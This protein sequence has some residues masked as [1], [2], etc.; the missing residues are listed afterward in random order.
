MKLSKIAEELGLMI[1]NEG[2]DLDREVT[3]GYVSDL[4]SDV[5]G[6]ANEGEL[7]ITL[8]SHV[9]V[10]AI[11]SLK[12]LAGIV[13]VKGILPDEKMLVKSTEEGIPVLGSSRGTFQTAGL[14]Y[15]LLEN[16]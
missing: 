11:A 15:K 9:N 6:H 7:W 8:Q 4:L 13:L 5:M 12:E 2:V 16:A 1:L 10:A 3:G 14:L